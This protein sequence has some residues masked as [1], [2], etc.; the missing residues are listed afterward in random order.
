MRI[1]RVIEGTATVALVV[2]PEHIARSPGGVTIA[3]SRPGAAVP[4]EWSG[5]S[6]RARRFTGLAIEPRVISARTV[7]M[8]G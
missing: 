4:G 2:G 1:A 6:A 8:A 7:D 3:L 5:G